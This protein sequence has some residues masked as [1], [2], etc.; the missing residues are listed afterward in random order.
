MS[1]N[2]RVQ[3]HRDKLKYHRRRLDLHLPKDLVEAAD[4][5]AKQN[6]RYI[7]HIVASALEDYL[8]RY[9]VVLTGTQRR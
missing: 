9:G 8:K 1:V 3:K 5:F 4:T 7:R 2:V 6:G